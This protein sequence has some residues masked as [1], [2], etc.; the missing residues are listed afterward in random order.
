MPAEIRVDKDSKS[1]TPGRTWID[2]IRRPTLRRDSHPR[3]RSP[4]N[5]FTV[6]NTLSGRSAR[7]RLL[8][9]ER[10]LAASNTTS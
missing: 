7:R 5:G 1:A 3:L 9:N 6:T 4:T 10:T 2:S 8:P